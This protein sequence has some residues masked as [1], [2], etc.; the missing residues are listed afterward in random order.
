MSGNADGYNKALNKLYERYGGPEGL[1][2]HLS[3]I[4]KRGGATKPRKGKRGFAAMDEAQHKAIAS[5]GGKAPRAKNS[6]DTIDKI[7]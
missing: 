7:E 3:E 1:R 4:G 5:K 2:K 6:K